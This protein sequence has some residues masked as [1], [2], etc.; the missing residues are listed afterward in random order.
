MHVLI[1]GANGFVGHALATRLAR[2]GALA[3][4]ALRR[5]S[6]V[7]L[8]FAGAPAREGIVHRLAGDLGDSAWLDAHLPGDPVDVVFHLASIPG[9]TAEANYAL[10]RRVNLDATLSLLER[11]KSQVEAGAICP[12]FVFASSVAVFGTLPELVTEAARPR[13]RMSYGAQKLIGEILVDDFSRRAWVDG[14]SLRIPGVLARPPAPTGQ[15]SAFLSDIIRE[16]AAG[17]SFVCPMSASA[18]TWASSLGNVVDNL[19][20]AA[21]L[22]H[23]VLSST[24]TFTLPTTRFSMAEL[25]EAIG[26]LRGSDTRARVRYEPDERIESLFGRFP[27]L[28]TPEAEYAGFLRDADL[29]ELVRRSLDSF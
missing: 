16:L 15:L 8:S 22:P 2:D 5:L 4:R 10:A 17:R 28:E 9:G 19:L 27:P 21:S 25:V 6:L 14:V 11:G 12:R 13:P 29:R 7:D 24:R 18:T 23:H 26:A 20:Y 1:T 3:G